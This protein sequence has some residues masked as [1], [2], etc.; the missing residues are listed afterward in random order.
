[1]DNINEMLRE[2]N[3]LKSYEAKKLFNGLTIGI[4]ANTNIYELGYLKVKGIYS[5]ESLKSSKIFYHRAMYNYIFSLFEE[6]LGSFLLEQTKNRFENQEELKNYLISNFSKDRYI[7]YQNLNK[8]NKYYKKLIGLDLKKIKNYN[9]IHFFMEFRHINTHNYGRFDK[10]F[11]ET[12]RII[13]FPKELEG[14][15][16]YIDFEFNKLVIKYIKEFAKDIDERVNK[17]KA[18]NKN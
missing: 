18:I 15:T 1:M 4:I 3:S 2:A 5:D 9:I 13:E 11:F 16:F 14:G 17:K 12:N 6:F 8:A 10:R 7:N